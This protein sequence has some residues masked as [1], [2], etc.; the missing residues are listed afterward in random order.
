MIF[1]LL[2]VIFAVHQVTAGNTFSQTKKDDLEA[3]G[4]SQI[5]KNSL[6][7]IVKKE[8][9]SL[10]DIENANIL[11]ELIPKTELNQ[12]EQGLDVYFI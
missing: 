1:N 12:Q 2:F 10:A 3:V 5:R 4:P 8:I 7:K 6:S 11:I 9:P